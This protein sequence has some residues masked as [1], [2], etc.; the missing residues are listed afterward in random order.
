MDQTRK[1]T[2]MVNT[3]SEKEEEKV[4][5]AEIINLVTMA[6]PIFSLLQE[7]GRYQGL[8]VWSERPGPHEWRRHG[9]CGEHARHRRARQQLTWRGRARG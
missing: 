1:S 3:T 9:V 4:E 6:L 5:G 7:G 2:A 8:R